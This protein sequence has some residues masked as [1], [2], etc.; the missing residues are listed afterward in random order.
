MDDDAINSSDVRN[1]SYHL[2]KA[3][4]ELFKDDDAK[5][6]PKLYRI[7]RKFSKKNGEEWNVLENNELVLKIQEYRLN[8]DEKSFLRTATGIQQLLTWVKQGVRSVS[9]IKDLIKE[10]LE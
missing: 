2:K 5:I 1:F 10:N 9:K 7:K 4:N 6:V 8:N 3:S